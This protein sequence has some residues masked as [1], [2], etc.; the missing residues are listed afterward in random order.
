MNITK[1]HTFCDKPMRT[2]KQKNQAR[3]IIQMCFK[4]FF[5]NLLL[6]RALSRKVR[7]LMMLSYFLKCRIRDRESYLPN[8]EKINDLERNF[9]VTCNSKTE[10]SLTERNWYIPKRT[11]TSE[12]VIMMMI[13]II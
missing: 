1:Y 5:Y 13:I 12:D 3:S 8:L 7:Q 11:V 2:G 6:A 9:L 4:K 10:I